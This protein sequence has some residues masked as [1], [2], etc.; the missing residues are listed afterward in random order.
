MGEHRATK[1]DREGGGERTERKRTTGVK[2]GGPYPRVDAHVGPGEIEGPHRVRGVHAATQPVRTEDVHEQ[3]GDGERDR[4]GLLH[5]REPPERPLAVELLHAHA[6][7][8]RQVRHRVRARV[9]ALVRARPTR[10]AQRER[11]RVAPTAAAGRVAGVPR[12]FC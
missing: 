6:A 2:H 3:V 1:G 5:A 4:G 12:V 8:E 11:V 10:Q 9:L 7:L